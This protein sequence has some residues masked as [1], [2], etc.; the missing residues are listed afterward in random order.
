MPADT[1]L[2]F[3]GAFDGTSNYMSDFSSRA[4][5]AP[6]KAIRPQGVEHDKNVP[7]AG[8]STYSDTFVKKASEGVCCCRG[9]C[10]LRLLWGLCQ[11]RGDAKL[12]DAPTA[13]D[14]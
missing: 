11:S 6:V 2:A 14:S 5:Q 3:A 7:F 1:G 9:V 8:H 10:L 12:G 4:Q 13:P